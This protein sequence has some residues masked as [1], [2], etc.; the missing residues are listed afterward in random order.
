MTQLQQ[1]SYHNIHTKAH[2]QELLKS[3]FSKSRDLNL[4]FLQVGLY[5][6]R[7]QITSNHEADCHQKARQKHAFF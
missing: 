3:R 7:Q 4:N 2:L 5:T 1:I 6:I